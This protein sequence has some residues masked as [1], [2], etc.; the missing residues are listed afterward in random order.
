MVDVADAA[1]VSETTASHALYHPDRV[2]PATRVRVRE[3][4]ER[5]G[6]EKSERLP[7]RQVVEPQAPAEAVGRLLEAV[8]S[9][10]DMRAA[11]DAAGLD[12]SEV[13][14]WSPKSELGMALDEAIRERNETSDDWPTWG[15]RRGRRGA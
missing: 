1:G 15:R 8:R 12:A 5:L 10:L 13:T 14:S 3:V 11:A 7:A 6:Y 4:A 2:G 9:G